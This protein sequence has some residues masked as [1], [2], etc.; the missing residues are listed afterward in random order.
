MEHPPPAPARRPMVARANHPHMIARAA[1][2]TAPQL[3]AHSF[4]SQAVQKSLEKQCKCHGVSGSCNIQTCW[5]ALPDLPKIGE[6]LQRKYRNAVEVSMRRVG[7]RWQMAPA[8]TAMGR[9]SH[10]D[11]IYN[12]KSPDYCVRDESF[13]SL[14]TIGR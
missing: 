6:R 4:C 9:F 14:G 1:L 12:A 3:T 7:A 5:R 11:L 8:T 10:D 2:M 13:G